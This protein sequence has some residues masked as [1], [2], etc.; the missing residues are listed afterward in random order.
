MNS[1]QRIQDAIDAK[2]PIHKIVI[3]VD[4]DSAVIVNLGNRVVPR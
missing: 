4:N 1:A 2:N 3:A